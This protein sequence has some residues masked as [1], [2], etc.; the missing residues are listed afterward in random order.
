[1][2]T[3]HVEKASTSGSTI[4]LESGNMTAGEQYRKM[5]EKKNSDNNLILTLKM[6]ITKDL[7]PHVS[8]C[9]H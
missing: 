4:G 7:F 1:M 3:V 8:E 5:E 9:C 2:E 6:F